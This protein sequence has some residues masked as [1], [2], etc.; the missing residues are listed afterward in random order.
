MFFSRNKNI[1]LKLAIFLIACF[2]FTYTIFATIEQ[3]ENRSVPDIP[4]FDV[5]NE[6]IYLNEYEGK[7]VLLVFWASWCGACINDLSDLDNLQRDFIKLPFKIIIISEDFLEKELIKNYA[8]KQEIRHL[9]IFYDYHNL[10]FKE[11]SVIG[12]PT[13]FLIDKNGMVKFVFKGNTKWHNS[14]VRE[15]ILSLIP[16]GYSLPK[17]TYKP[18]LFIKNHKIMND[19]EQ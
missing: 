17:N 19:D 15:T 14:E 6:K 7:T 9:E 13:S 18:A 16:E 8:D 1:Y 5:N 3:I 2:S 4:F 10:L 12:L 11:M